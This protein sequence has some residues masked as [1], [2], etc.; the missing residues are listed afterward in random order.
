MN[1]T[2]TGKTVYLLIICLLGFNVLIKAQN[3]VRDPIDIE[4]KIN[5]LLQKMTLEEK[6]GQMNQYNGF[7]EI[8]GPAPKNGDAKMKYDN[9]RKGMVGAV[10]NVKGT[11]NVRKLQEIAVKETRLGIPLLFGY[12]VIHGHK[13]LFPIPLGEAASWDLIALQHHQLI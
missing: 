10:L 2:I 1:H 5:A 9:L 11:K 6:A 13:T 8:T 3:S 12:D 7:W 4:E